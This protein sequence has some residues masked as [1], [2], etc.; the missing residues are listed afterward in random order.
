[1]TTS[2]PLTAQN[3]AHNS[4]NCMQLSFAE[5]ALGDTRQAI[6]DRNNH[7]MMAQLSPMK[8]HSFFNRSIDRNPI[9]IEGVEDGGCYPI[10]IRGN[11][12]SYMLL[13]V[14]Q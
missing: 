10:Q 1:M 4:F 5:P 12:P 14:P 11:I 6:E 8:Q 9:E 13:E 3:L 2:S 7:Y